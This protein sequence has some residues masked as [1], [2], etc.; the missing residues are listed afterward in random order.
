MGLLIKKCN[1]CGAMVEVL[2]DCHCSNCG[3]KCCNQNMETLK[4]NLEEFSKE[5]HLPKIEICGENIEVSVPHTMEEEHYIMW[6]SLVTDK[7]VDKIFLKPNESAK[8]TF[9]YIKASK[10]YA[11]CNKHGLWSNTVE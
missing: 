3:I 7:I 11:Y 8:A 6:I 1:K 9:P 4:E 5:K 10:V 2:V